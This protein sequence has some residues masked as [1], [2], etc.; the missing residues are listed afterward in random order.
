MGRE[1][2]WKPG[3]QEEKRSL[4]FFPGF[5]DPRFNPLFLVKDRLEAAAALVSGDLDEE[6]FHLTELRIGNQSGNQ[7]ARKRED[8]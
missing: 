1:L 4:V 3:N 2:I 8:S 5:V 7:E 6:D